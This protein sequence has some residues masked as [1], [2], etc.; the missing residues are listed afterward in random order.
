MIKTYLLLG[1]FKVIDIDNDNEVVKKIMVVVE[2]GWPR[3]DPADAASDVKDKNNLGQNDRDAALLKLAKLGH[4]DFVKQMIE[5]GADIDVQNKPESLMEAFKNSSESLGVE[6]P[7]LVFTAQFPQKPSF[8][9]ADLDPQQQKKR[10]DLQAEG[11]AYFTKLCQDILI[12]EYDAMNEKSIFFKKGIKDFEEY[13]LDK[14]SK[15][16][17]TEPVIN[18]ICDCFYYKIFHS[19]RTLMG[20]IIEIKTWK[21]KCILSKVRLERRLNQLKGMKRSL[22]GDIENIS[23][24]TKPPA[25]VA[26]EYIY[27]LMALQYVHDASVG[28]STSALLESPRRTEAYYQTCKMI[29]AFLDE[30]EKPPTSDTLAKGLKRL[31]KY[32]DQGVD[33]V[34]LY[35]DALAMSHSY[36]REHLLEAALQSRQ[37]KQVQKNWMKMHRREGARS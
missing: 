15:A 8:E 19:E 22:E 2:G 3:F 10:Q 28:E 36:H 11:E 26:Q 5:A 25:W 7:K 23:G 6:T 27:K 35:Q 17:H 30:L 37:S 24:S 18:Y 33:M 13:Y 21:R 32:A 29:E 16:P 1:V 31:R 34:G 14:Y 12:A 4:L 20:E 9:I